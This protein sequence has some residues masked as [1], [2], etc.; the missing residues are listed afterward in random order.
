MKLLII[1]AAVIATATACGENEY[2][3]ECG[4][5]CPVTCANYETPPEV[6]ITL[7]VAG[8]FCEEGL[9]WNSTGTCVAVEDC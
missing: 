7:C 1:L 9:Y 2:Y 4:T 8:C 5:A 3:T 6:C